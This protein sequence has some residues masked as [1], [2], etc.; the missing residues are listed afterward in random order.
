M[1]KCMSFPSGDSSSL[2]TWQGP[3]QYNKHKLEEYEPMD[4]LEREELR[5]WYIVYHFLP[6]GRRQDTEC[7]LSIEDNETG[8]NDAIVGTCSV[9]DFANC[10]DQ[11]LTER[12]SWR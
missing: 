8:K 10:C 9:S 4:S 6:V 7:E 1:L 12:K 5:R 11:I 3:N 2:S